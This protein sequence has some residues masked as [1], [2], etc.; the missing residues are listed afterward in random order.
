MLAAG[1]KAPAFRLATLDGS[2]TTLAETLEAGP[3]V[4]AFFKISCPT[5]RYSLPF[6]QRMAGSDRARM[7]AISQDD[8]AGTNEFHQE[9]G[10]TMPTLLDH[11]GYAV[12]KAF[13]ITHVPS[14]FVVEPDGAIS[15][16]FMGF[17]KDDFEE[18]G[19]RL[20][21]APF[22]DGERVQRFKP[23]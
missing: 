20:G 13:E 18:L 9:F 19:A 12:A 10:I 3:A 7:V 21:V 14:I 4:L 1:T 11:K 17:S 23:G 5:C 16:S 22:R 6:L 15:K 2:E 8:A